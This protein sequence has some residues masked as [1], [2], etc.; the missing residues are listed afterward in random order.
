MFSGEISRNGIAGQ[1]LNA[2]DA[3]FA[4]SHPQGPPHF[5][6]LPSPDG[7]AHSPHRGQ[8][9]A[10]KPLNFCHIHRWEMISQCGFNLHSSFYSK[11]EHLFLK[12][13][14]VYLVIYFWLRW[15]FVAAR[16]LSLVA[17]SGVYSSLRCAGF[18][19]RWL[20]LLRS[21]GSRY[22]G[23]SSCGWQAQ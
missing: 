12:N 23:F 10:F 13:K 3:W 19:L 4:I 17:A 22:V 20:L 8:Q 1:S 18:S 15:V 7:S 11:V 9:R 14:F 16:G 2:Y 21:M 6:H 5:A